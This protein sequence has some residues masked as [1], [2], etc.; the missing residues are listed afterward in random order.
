MGKGGVG[1]VCMC[2]F[3]IDLFMSLGCG[4]VELQSISARLHLQTSRGKENQPDSLLQLFSLKRAVFSKLS[5]H[6]PSHLR[7]CSV[8]GAYKQGAIRH[9]MGNLHEKRFTTCMF[10]HP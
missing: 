2:G 7:V 3:L 10:E 9:L 8:C 1:G 5:H 4:G 6:I